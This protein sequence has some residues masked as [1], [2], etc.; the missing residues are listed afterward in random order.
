MQRDRF[1]GNGL[2][3]NGKVSTGILGGEVIRYRG[4]P[5][6]G[7][8]A[9]RGGN[10]DVDSPV[11]QR[12]P[13]LIIGLELAVLDPSVKKLHPNGGG[14]AWEILDPLDVVRRECLYGNVLTHGDTR[15]RNKIKSIGVIVVV[16]AVALAGDTHVPHI[17][18]REI[19]G[20]GRGIAA[21]NT[22]VS[23][24]QTIAPE[25]DIHGTGGIN[26]N[27]GSSAPIVSRRPHDFTDIVALDVQAGVI[28][29]I[30]IARKDRMRTIAFIAGQLQIDR[31]LCISPNGQ[32]F[33]KD[34]LGGQH[35]VRAYIVIG[36]NGQRTAAVY[37]ERQS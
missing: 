18:Y 35:L 15:V 5:I 11:F 31:Y 14:E 10:G 12:P 29:H 28:E 6:K 2:T 20:I 1:V 36:V 3:I 32:A 19:G 16:G 23:T 26:A 33:G 37:D 8:R 22:R 30:E 34:T 7:S 24:L 21:E 13:Q 17:L 9:F 4:P 25:L 27:E